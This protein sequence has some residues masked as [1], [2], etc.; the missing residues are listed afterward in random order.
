MEKIKHALET[1]VE[2]S[3]LHSKRVEKIQSA[4]ETSV[5]D[6][7]LHSK[8]VKKS[9]PAKGSPTDKQIILKSATFRG[10]KTTET[11]QPTRKYQEPG[12][13]P[14]TSRSRRTL[15]KT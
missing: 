14:F 15:E 13:P 9:K 5:E 8:R 6:S 2:D 12:I 11:K 1:S 4:L 3:R 7:K 10:N